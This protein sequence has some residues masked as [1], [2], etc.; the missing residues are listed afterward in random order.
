MVISPDNLCTCTMMQ[1]T[2]AILWDQSRLK[3][4]WPR[5]CTILEDVR[6]IINN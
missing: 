1:H 5:V 4:A 2:A 6:W 3:L